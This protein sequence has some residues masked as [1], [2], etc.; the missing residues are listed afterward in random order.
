VTNLVQK[1]D[2]DLDDFNKY[3]QQFGQ[4]IQQAG[5]DFASPKNCDE[6]DLAC[7]F[8]KLKL[9]NTSFNYFS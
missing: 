9:L 2:L 6:G 5:M 4:T 3:A 1:N 7:Q 8:G